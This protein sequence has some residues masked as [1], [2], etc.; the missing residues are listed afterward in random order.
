MQSS[1]TSK[2]HGWRIALA[3]L[4]FGTIAA[5]GVGAAPARAEG[6]HRGSEHHE[7]GRGHDW[8]RHWRG[9]GW[10]WHGPRWYGWGW[11]DPPPAVYV[12]A[13]PPVVYPPPAYYP[14]GLGVYIPLR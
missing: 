9:W 11:Y 2:R 13:P 1:N 5:V 14:G 12:P 8:D 4:A 6:W 3:A 7:W 10:G